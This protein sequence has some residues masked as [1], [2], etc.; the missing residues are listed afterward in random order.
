MSKVTFLIPA[1]PTHSFFS[2]I[3]AFNVALKS[4]SWTEWQPSVL[5]CMGTGPGT[6]EFAEW[7]SYLDDITFIFVSSLESEN[8]PF[9]YAQIDGLFRWAPLD[10]DVLVRVDADTLAVGEFED[11]LDYV[12][13]TD[14]IAGVMAHFAFPTA[15]I[16]SR[17]AWL[18][19]ADGLITSPL[20]FRYSYSLT[21]PDAPEGN[22]FAPFYLNDGAVFFPKSLFREFAERYLQLRPEVMKRLAYPYFAGQ[23]ALALAVSE[24]SAR[25]CA[26]PMRYNFPNDELAT[27]KFP[28]ELASVKIFHYLRTDQFDRQLIFADASHYK[29]FL[30]APLT[31]SNKVFQQ[32][33]RHRIGPAFPLSTIPG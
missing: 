11:V 20:D 32:A 12:V 9:Y 1:S 2:Q 18:R 28:E 25:T 23:V 3:A 30:H 15:G 16:S 6:N 14:S 19:I 31:G 10:A 26:L 27:R 17:E 13:A 8:I 4:L 33:V 21:E 29:A 7:R 5:V 22:R 24:M